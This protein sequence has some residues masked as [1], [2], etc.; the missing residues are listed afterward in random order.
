[1]SSVLNHHVRTKYKLPWEGEVGIDQ[2][3]MS[4]SEDQIG[5]GQEKGNMDGKEDWGI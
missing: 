4:C 5:D 2:K 3:A 1:M